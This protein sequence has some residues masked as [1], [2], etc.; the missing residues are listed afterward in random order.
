[1]T[2]ES[3]WIRDLYDLLLPAWPSPVVALN[4]VA[5]VSMVGGPAAGLAVLDTLRD[6]ARLNA[7]YYLSAARADLL[8]RLGRA[9]EAAAEYRRALVGFDNEAERAFLSRR[10]AEVAR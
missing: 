7:Y 4:R 6:D 3:R 1:V 5:A 2:R 10:L 8:R 9:A